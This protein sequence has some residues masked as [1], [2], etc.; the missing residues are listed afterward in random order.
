MLSPMSGL[1]QRRTARVPIEIK[2]EYKRI[3]AFIADFT[4]DISGGGLFVRTDTPMPVGSEALFTL[5]IPRMEKPVTLK[6]IVRRVVA[7]G[8]PTTEAGMGVELLFDD[9]QERVALKRVVDALMIEHLGEALYRRFV[10]TQKPAD[11]G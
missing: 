10:E 4:R 5:A 3:N 9:E 1:H 6:G 11:A 8:D 2:V 7:K